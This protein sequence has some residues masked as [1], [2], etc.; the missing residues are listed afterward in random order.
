LHAGESTT[1][2]YG[3]RYV[4]NKGYGYYEAKQFDFTFFDDQEQTKR[5]W[6]L[7]NPL[8]KG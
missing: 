1:L 3:F 4:G 7:S 6:R 8:V 5:Y 2:T